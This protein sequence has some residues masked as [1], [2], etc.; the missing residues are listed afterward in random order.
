MNI[1]EKSY[2][3]SSRNIRNIHESVTCAICLVICLEPN[4]TGLFT[5]VVKCVGTEY[6][7]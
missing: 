4:L 1:V 3:I 6:S 7:S 2:E 5:F